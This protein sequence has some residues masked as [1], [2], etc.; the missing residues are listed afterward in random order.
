MTEGADRDLFVRAFVAAALPD[1]VRA[2]LDGVQTLLRRSR[3]DVSWVPRENLHVSLAFLGNITREDVLAVARTLDE[4]ACSERPFRFS[5]AGL[6]AFGPP[7]SPRVLWAGGRGAEPLVRLQ[8][9][10]AEGLRGL[11]LTLDSREFR[12][13]VTLGR[14][15]SRLNVEAL[16]ERVSARREDE[17]GD[18]DVERIHLMR[19]VLR[20]S[21]SQ[22]SVLHE[23]AL[24]R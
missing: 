17:F 13:H 8:A 20:P 21:G 10:V 9:A 12:P 1:P 6:G 14:V 7:R 2:A 4:A 19:S 5:V 24:P 11:R 15:R 22:Y 16:M 3:A 23:A 18:V